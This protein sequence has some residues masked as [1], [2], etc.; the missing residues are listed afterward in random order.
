MRLLC[1]SWNAKTE[2]RGSGERT[3]VVA[4]PG[5]PRILDLLGDPG[6]IVGAAGDDRHRDDLRSVVG[7]LVGDEFGELIEPFDRGLEDHDPLLGGL[8]LAFPPIGAGDRPDQLRARGQP[9]A[10]RRLGQLGR[11][12]PRV[13]GS[14]HLHV[15]AVHITSPTWPIVGAQGAGRTTSALPPCRRTGS[16]TAWIRPRPR[17]S[18][19]VAAPITPAGGPGNNW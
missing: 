17:N 13:G 11:L 12:R 14:G 3:S 6:E 15:R 1:V 7:V 2:T 9:L 19:P 16:A 18:R 5:I 4:F 8:D 10:Y